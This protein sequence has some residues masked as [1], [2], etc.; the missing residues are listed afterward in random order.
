VATVGGASKLGFAAAVAGDEVKRGAAPYASTM[1]M[2][3]ATAAA[4]A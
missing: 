2:V 4:G 3:Y 1:T